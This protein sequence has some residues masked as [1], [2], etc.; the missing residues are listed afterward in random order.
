METRIELWDDSLVVRIPA[1]V[2][3]RLG[4]RRGDA[5]SVATRGDSLTVTPTGDPPVRLKELLDMVTD[6]NRH[7]EIY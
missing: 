7:E 4:F 1:E 3:D 5:V 2:A 6:E